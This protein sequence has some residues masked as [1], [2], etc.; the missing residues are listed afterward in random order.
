MVQSFA[1][2]NLTLPELEEKQNLK[3]TDEPDFFTEWR[4]ALPAISDDE[5][6]YLDQVQQEYFDQTRNGQIS[7]GLIKLMVVSPLLHLRSG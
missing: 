3:L 7:E 6:R 2:S 5:K 1:I 4:E